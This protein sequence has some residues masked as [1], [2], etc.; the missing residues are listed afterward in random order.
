MKKFLMAAAGAVFFFCFAVPS[1]S[2][3]V[4]V[5]D[6]GDIEEKA[7]FEGV[8][9]VRVTRNIRIR[10]GGPVP[11]TFFY[12]Y[13][14]GPAEG[15]EVP[16]G[17]PSFPRLGDHTAGSLGIGLT[18]SAWYANGFLGARLDGRNVNAIADE[19]TVSGGEKSGEV[20]F[21]WDE[22]WGTMDIRFVQAAGDDKIFIKADFSGV[23]DKNVILRLLSFPGHWG[24]AAVPVDRW[25]ATSARSFQGESTLEMP[26]ENWI[27]AFDANDNTRGS[28]ALLFLAEELDSAEINVDTGIWKILRLKKGGGSCRMILWSIP[29]RHRTPEQA[30]QYL[31]ENAEKYTADLRAFQF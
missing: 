1:H 29:D 28:A 17:F 24:S 3:G 8:E 13:N 16:P 11:Y 2:A 21:S 20:K 12:R 5:E 7:A 25:G 27:L 10:A 18:G 23:E 19:I 4:T 9:L 26:A 30:Y 31:S 6:S 15:T 22:Q 14:P